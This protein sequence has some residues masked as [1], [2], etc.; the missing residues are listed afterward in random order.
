MLKFLSVHQR[1]YRLVY[2]YNYR[3]SYFFLISEA[4]K[5][6]VVVVYT[7]DQQWGAVASALAQVDEIVKENKARCLKNIFIL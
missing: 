3:F 5:Q 7:S 6:N 4:E 2:R 1:V